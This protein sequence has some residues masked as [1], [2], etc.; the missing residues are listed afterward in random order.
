MAK[1]TAPR[2]ATDPPRRACR[3]WGIRPIR[4]AMEL[5]TPAD[6]ND[7]GVLNLGDVVTFRTHL[8][9]PVG[10]PLSAAGEGQCTVIGLVR[11][12]DILD[13]TVV[14][15]ALGI[16]SLLP[17]IAPVCEAAVGA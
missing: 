17:G 16:P 3:V 15:R 5:A 4:M 9:N 7:D 14:R 8:A 2:L 13:V 1:T 12:C 6:V 11:P 10:V